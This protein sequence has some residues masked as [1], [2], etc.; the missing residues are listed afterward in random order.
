[1]KSKN[2][3]AVKGWDYLL[4]AE[5]IHPAVLKAARSLGFMP[6]MKELEE[7]LCCEH[8]EAQ[9]GKVAGILKEGGRKLLTWE[10]WRAFSDPIQKRQKAAYSAIMKRGPSRGS[11]KM[12]KGWQN[13]SGHC[14][15]QP[16]PPFSEAAL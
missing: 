10:E 16:V 6:T 2:G 12:P 3:K 9:R 15:V 13:V 11:G 1:M 5:N 7:A 8:E 4:T 14:I